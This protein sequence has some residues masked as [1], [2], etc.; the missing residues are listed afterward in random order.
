MARKLSYHPIAKLS[1][2]ALWAAVCAALVIRTVDAEGAFEGHK[3]L[4]PSIQLAEANVKMTPQQERAA[5]QVFAKPHPEALQQH[6]QALADAEVAAHRW[7]QHAD[8]V[9]AWQ[10]WVRGQL[11]QALA[12]PGPADARV[13]AQVCG[14]I[15]LDICTIERVQVRTAPHVYCVANLYI[16]RGLKHPA[17]GILLLFGHGDRLWS[18][19]AVARR[20]VEQGY[21]VLAVEPYGAGETGHDPAKNEYHGG[22]S[23]AGLLA[24]GLPLSGLVIY[25]HIHAFNY[26]R[27]R[28]EVD[29][30]RIGVTGV[31]GGASHT[32]FM[33]AADGRAAAYAPASAALWI[34][35]PREFWKAHCWCDTVPGLFQFAEEQALVACG[36]PGAWL[37]I[38]LAPEVTEFSAEQ[39]RQMQAH[40]EAVYRLAGAGG[41]IDME[42]VDSIHGYTPAVQERVSRWFH[43]WLR[44][45]QQPVADS[46]LPAK[47]KEPLKTA[48][49]VWQKGRPADALTPTQLAVA[50]IKQ[51]LAAMPQAPADRPEA[52]AVCA[53]TRRKLA[54]VLGC[55]GPALGSV[56]VVGKRPGRQGMVTQA[57][58]ELKTGLQIPFVVETPTGIERPPVVL[59]LHPDGKQAAAQWSL[60]ERLLAE[61]WAVASMDL[62]GRGEV[63]ASYERMGY[64]GSRDQQTC[65]AALKLGQSL[66]GWWAQEVLAVARWLQG[67]D[68]LAAEKVACVARDETSFAALIAGAQDGRLSP[69]VLLRPLASYYSPAGYGKP[70]F[71]RERQRIGGLGTYV[72]YVPDIVAAGDVDHFIGLLAPRPVMIMGPVAA[73]GTALT[74]SQVQSL[75][76]WSRSIW[77][78]YGARSN[79]RIYT[80][81][82]VRRISDWLGSVC[83]Q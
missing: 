15:E 20:Y 42:I 64:A 70:Y 4:L 12:F 81:P 71:Y 40:A 74:R 52:E 75:L 68:W 8:E 82:N 35:Q 62:L 76:P 29:A 18:Y 57:V 1:I 69:L 23:V 22:M 21:V 13:K 41:R 56:H 36:C 25:N 48:L 67:R 45:T 46:S 80:R 78:T 72:W 11:R 9:A 66:A 31:S 47:P 50:T 61:G 79:L 51:K 65:M 26:L 43:R 16:P 28:P 77:A 27:S 17:P 59:I 73:D 83:G 6:L 38:H 19:F 33:A 37:R 60:T 3:Q 10:S 7:P 2:I 30:E 24:A 63:P 54:Q 58:L 55:W 14:K 34:A 5:W 49:V 44:P 32:L 53:V 39:L